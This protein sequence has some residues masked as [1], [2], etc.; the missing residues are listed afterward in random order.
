MHIHRVSNGSV[1]CW[2]AVQFF[3][4]LFRN[5]TILHIICICISP[6]FFFFFFQ[7]R[8]KSKQIRLSELKRSIVKEEWSTYK[9]ARYSHIEKDDW[10]YRKY[11]VN[12]LLI[13]NLS[14][15]ATFHFWKV[16]V[17][18]LLK[19]YLHMHSSCLLP[20]LYT[21]YFMLEQSAITV[22]LADCAKLQKEL[23]IEL[24]WRWSIYFTYY[25]FH[26]IYSLVSSFDMFI[27]TCRKPLTQEQ[28]KLTLRK[29]RR[30][31][32]PVKLCTG[33]VNIFLYCEFICK[34]SLSNMYFPTRV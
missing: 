7:C 11:Y 29:K 13:P 15:S 31:F 4:F 19:C 26:E 18:Y 21:S 32:L 1:V 3:N 6:F 25:A 14:F 10:P 28:K 23:K 5:P 12:R 16:V 30:R 8:F 34:F 33:K 20:G 22:T 2:S 24:D 27:L 17:H 9:R